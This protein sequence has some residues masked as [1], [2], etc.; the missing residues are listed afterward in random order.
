MPY[1]GGLDLDMQ[2]AARLVNANVITFWSKVALQHAATL[3][4]SKICFPRAR[5]GTDMLPSEFNNNMSVSY[6]VLYCTVL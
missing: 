3:N 5:M 1:L 6:K 4:E 2:A